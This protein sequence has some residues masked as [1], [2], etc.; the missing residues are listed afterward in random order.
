MALGKERLDF[1]K[2]V[3]DPGRAIPRA[4]QEISRDLQVSSDQPSADLVIL[5]PRKLVDCPACELL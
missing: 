5:Q 1:V 2:Q 4:R 3:R